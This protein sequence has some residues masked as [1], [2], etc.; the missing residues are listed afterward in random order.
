MSTPTSVDSS[1]APQVLV[2]QG[3]KPGATI[4]NTDANT[5]YVLIG[6]GTVSATNHT[7]ALASGDY[8]E[9]PSFYNGEI[10]TGVWA[11][12]GSG[13]ALITVF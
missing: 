2:A 4:R 10:I 6:T 11:A 12:D 1:T 8:F 3:D 9:T 13:A 5:L 7:V